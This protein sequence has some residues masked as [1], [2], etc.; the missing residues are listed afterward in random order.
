M[1][2]FARATETS[3]GPERVAKGAPNSC[4]P[5]RGRNLPTR[6]PCVLMAAVAGNSSVAGWWQLANKSAGAALA[7]PQKSLKFHKIKMSQK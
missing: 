7:G 2:L 3:E 5:R 4:Y 6:T 1:A